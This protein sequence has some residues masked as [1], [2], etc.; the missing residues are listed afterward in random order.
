MA[1]ASQPEAVAT[2]I[3]VVMPGLDLGI[4]HQSS[5]SEGMNC[6][7][8]PGHDVSESTGGALGRPGAYSLNSS[9]R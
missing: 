4:H 9:P 7:V 1:A 5:F 6:R 2:W 8:K 3:E